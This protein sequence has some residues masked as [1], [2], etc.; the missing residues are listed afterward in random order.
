ME[1]GQP[2]PFPIVH[3]RNTFILPGI[4]ALLQQKWK[5][6]ADFFTRAVQFCSMRAS[7]CMHSALSHSRAASS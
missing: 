7:T 5:A 1:S 6:R 3:I 4:P 2:S